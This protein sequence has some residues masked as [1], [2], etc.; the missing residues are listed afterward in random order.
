MLKNRFTKKISCFLAITI[1]V[2]S[3]NANNIF[4]SQSEENST[5]TKLGTTIVLPSYITDWSDA[6]DT[7]GM[8]GSV[9]RSYSASVTGEDKNTIKPR[10][11]EKG[12]GYNNSYALAVGDKSIP[13]TDYTISF[14]FPS[15]GTLSNNVN[16]TLEFMLKCDGKLDS[17]T[18][19]FYP[20]N[21]VK[22]T[23]SYSKSIDVEDLNDGWNKIEFT[24]NSSKI[25]SKHQS[26]V[27]FKFT[28]VEGVRLL[29]D[30]I[31]VYKADD[32]EK[33]DRLL[34]GSFETI[35]YKDTFK[36]GSY[37]N[38]SYLP[39]A[40]DKVNNPN[41]Y[42]IGSDFVANS[43]KCSL[44]DSQG[45]AGSYALQLNGDGKNTDILL[46]MQSKSFLEKKTEYVLGFK[47]KSSD[48]DKILSFNL[49][50]LEDD[51]KTIALSL[52]KDN[53]VDLVGEE[54]SYYKVKFVSSNNVAKDNYI[55]INFTALCDAKIYLDEIELFRA[56]DAN[57]FNL[58]SK[59]KFEYS[60]S[61][62]AI[63]DNVDDQITYKPIDISKYNSHSSAERTL[64]YSQNVSIV[65]NGINSSYALEIK[66]NGKEQIFNL[67]MKSHTNSFVENTKYNISFD[68]KKSGNIDRVGFGYTIAQKDYAG[69]EISNEEVIDNYLGFCTQVIAPSVI[70]EKDDKG[71]YIIQEIW[72]SV[73]APEGSSVYID[74]I[75]IDEIGG[76]ANKV[77]GS[78][79]EYGYYSYPVIEVNTGETY[80]PAELTSYLSMEID[81]KPYDGTQNI[82]ISKNGG[83]NNS[84]ALKIVGDGKKHIIHFTFN[85][86]SILQNNTEY[87]LEFKIKRSGNI[88]TFSFG[89]MEQWT[90]HPAISFE[91][92]DLDEAITEKF[93]HYKVKYT[94]TAECY[95]S[96]NKLFIEYNAAE[97]SELYL[98]DISVKASLPER[99][100]FVDAKGESMNIFAGGSFEFISKQGEP[101]KINDVE[102]SNFTPFIAPSGNIDNITKR[103]IA[104]VTT[105]SNAPKGDYCLKIGFFE[106]SN[107]DGEYTEP[108][109]GTKPGKSYKISLWVKLYGD[110]TDAT[111]YIFNGLWRPV[112]LPIQLS[113]YEYGKWTKLE[114][115]YN[116]MT[117]M[118]NCQTYRLLGFKFKGE[119]GSGMLV[120][121]ICVYEIVSKGISPNFANNGNY[122][123]NKEYPKVVWDDRYIHKVGEKN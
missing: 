118:Y 91:S 49:G 36:A 103:K 35:C 41:L 26:R 52:L 88:E 57:K 93:V 99:S 45:V 6:V 17:L 109:I 19:A 75:T 20:K 70:L 11:S 116:D 34:L 50:I 44:V 86:N 25:A 104:D 33:N 98:D 8:T 4:Y 76:T 81:S 122:E 43:G 40:I 79:F 112:P 59:G 16:Y 58:F 37:P 55:L 39:Y 65:K 80:I 48:L 23:S 21:E 14:D 42:G 68:I 9:P 31:V 113:S 60:Y 46:T 77:F 15:V 2:T 54:Y 18:T 28:S 22:I 56:D 1:L 53:I 106:D 100:V 32:V 27:I 73:Y 29:L 95:G 101:L 85:E 69:I 92:S 121:D 87:I 51:K 30:D 12:E 64:A 61:S 5:K 119:A 89:L 3:L 108:L 120:D 115:I 7:E 82:S 62:E 47:I 107:V 63:K 105:C 110:V 38:G 13:V 24:F 78:E 71:N 96:W 123:E 94:T 84:P 117:D 10:F 67:P 97:N 83:I 66:G 72:I 102:Q 111:M 114:F 90:E 74:N